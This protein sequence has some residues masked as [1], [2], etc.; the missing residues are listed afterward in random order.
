MHN[1]RRNNLCYHHL[2][3]LKSLFNNNNNNN[4]KAA[5]IANENL[6]RWQSLL[7]AL[8]QNIT[9]KSLARITEEQK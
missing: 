7:F 4:T 3:T 1:E 6:L 5:N 8:I 9:K 2:A